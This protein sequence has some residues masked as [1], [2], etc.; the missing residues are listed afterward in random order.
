MTLCISHKT[1]PSKVENFLAKVILALRPSAL[2]PTVSL[3]IRYF[4]IQFSSKKIVL[5]VKGRVK[6]KVK[7]QGKSCTCSI[8]QSVT[9]SNCKVR[10]YLTPFPTQVTL[11]KLFLRKLHPGQS[12]WRFWSLPV[13]SSFLITPLALSAN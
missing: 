5:D 1:G 2:G 4:Q 3:R 13:C 9:R 12:S 7:M 10:I 11:E 8:W 6:V